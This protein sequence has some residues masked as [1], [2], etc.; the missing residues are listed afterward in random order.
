MNG[1]NRCLVTPKS[2]VSCLPYDKR[3]DHSAELPRTHS[4]LVKFAFGDPEYDKVSDV[5]R[6]MEQDSLISSRIAGGT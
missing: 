2:A 5:L 1:P 6:R 4:E 3:S